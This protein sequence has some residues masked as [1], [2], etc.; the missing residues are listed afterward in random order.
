MLNYRN[1]IVIITIS[2]LGNFGVKLFL[3]RLKAL[4]LIV[5]VLTSFS[6]GME[7]DVDGLSVIFPYDF[8]Y[9]EQYDYMCDLKRILDA[10]GHGLLEMPSG[11]GKT[12]TLL[13]FMLAYQ[14]AHPQA[15]ARLVYCTRTVPEVEKTLEELAR[16]VEYRKQAGCPEDIVALGLSARKNLCINPNVQLNSPKQSVD[17]QC[18][19]LTAPWV[20]DNAKAEKCAFFEDLESLP[21]WSLAPG[22]YTLEDLRQVGK[23]SG[24]CPYFMARKAIATANIVIFSFYY[25]LDPKVADLVSK[26]LSRSCIVVFDEAHN[27]DNVCIESLSI[28]LDLRCIDS[29]LRSLNKLAGV[30]HERKAENTQALQDEYNRL[31]EGLRLA[32]DNRINQLQLSNPVIPDDILQEAV[33][34]NIRTAEHFLALLRRFIE[35]LRIRFKRRYVSSETPQVFLQDVRNECM[36]DRKP[37]RFC[38]ERLAS[39]VRT[40]EIA[41]LDEF[42]FLQRIS[43]F[44]TLVS[45]YTK[46]FMVIYEPFEDDSNN[47]QFNPVL[48]LCCFDATLAIRPIFERFRSVIITSGTLSPLEMYPQL[49][50]FAPVL[51]RSFPMTLSRKS[52]EPLIVTR[53]NDQVSISSRFSVRN[54]PAVVR[55]YGLLLID[56]AKLTPDGMVCFFPSY[57]YLQSIISVWNETGILKELQNRKLLF[58][59]TQDIL[60]TSIVLGKFRDAC[61][62][63]RGAIMFSVARGK[64]SEGIDFERHYG[65]CVV[66]IGIPFQYTESRI[67]KARLEYLRENYGIKEGDFL[68]F[69]ALRHAAQ[70][71]GRVLRGK[72][73]YGL[74]V[75]ADRRYSRADKR[76]KLPRWISTE[77]KESCANL[78]SE[79]AVEIAREYFRQMA[80]PFELKAQ[81][82]HSLLSLG[83]VER[84]K[85]FQNAPFDP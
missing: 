43:F 26:E 40:L 77:I 9:P 4:Y 62:Q 19:E 17:S 28:D 79:M 1:S 46:G 38:A 75:L 80:E 24:L 83:D 74:M 41:Q 25:L 39:L 76:S 63:G 44:A 69:D 82:G 54:D 5:G 15:D 84:R 18:H 64:V 55:N 2:V 16:L 45:T 7:L 70:C 6:L 78:S 10:K 42:S 66:L 56:L 27:I 8:I 52:V 20:R 47:A 31:V 60:E 34:G 23:S 68:T 22:V 35:F 67:L 33:P 49:L 3:F 58:F 48:H 50:D 57:I 13:S 12:I 85:N 59:E 53:G 61:D 21:S 71:L 14:A 73:D 32:Q 36:I 37:L 29:G 11:T 65:R 30:V 72:S 51:M 81:L